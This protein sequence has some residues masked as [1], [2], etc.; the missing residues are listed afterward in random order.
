MSHNGTQLSRITLLL[1][2]NADHVV[3]LQWPH[4]GDS[5][6]VATIARAV[7]NGSNL[8]QSASHLFS[9]VKD[10]FLRDHAR[11]RDKNLA[12]DIENN[13]RRI[14]ATTPKG[15]LLERLTMSEQKVRNSNCSSKDE[16]KTYFTEKA[17]HL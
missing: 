1:V 14:E 13:K 8:K 16:S 7:M 17:I 10:Q 3:S 11:H 12:E 4:L 6:R 9:T 2:N 15:T 5:G